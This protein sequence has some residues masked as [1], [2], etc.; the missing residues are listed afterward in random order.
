MPELDSALIELRRFAASPPAAPA[1]M[2]SVIRQ[3]LLLVGRR[4]RL[5]RAGAA[6][7]VVAAAAVALVVAVNEDAPPEPRA[8][9]GP[10]A[11]IES[12]VRSEGL[13]VQPATGLAP[14]DQVSIA[15]PA[16]PAP[17]ATIVQCAS[18]A[19]GELE[20]WCDATSWQLVSG[21]PPDYRASVVRVIQ[22]DHG[23]IDCADRPQRCLIAVRSE[24]HGHAAPI[25]FRA[26]LAPIAEPGLS[27]DR[28]EVSDG[29]R[30]RM[31]GSGF[32]PGAEVRVTQCRRGR[33]QGPVDDFAG[34]DTARTLLV[35]ADA[36]GRFERRILLFR[37]VFEPKSGWVACD[38][39]VLRA[40]AVGQLPATVPLHVIDGGEP[41]AADRADRSG[42]SLPTGS[43]RP[44]PRVGVRGR[45]RR[46]HH[47]M[48]PVRHRRSSHRGAGRGIGAGGLLLPCG[49]LRRPA[50]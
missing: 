10:E 2:A 1:P 23:L 31:L 25:S 26:D 17:G 20:G 29:E 50:R 41:D 8:E 13:T 11:A 38:P 16:D 40:D 32:T 45:L 4:R 15:L 47:R 43:A 9:H 5:T 49:R 36:S 6:F 18:E 37:E 33:G 42:R 30:V 12:T 22:T 48:V 46:D 14:G 27:V 24:G 35:D 39:C 44:A 19:L 7:A 21:G 28:S 3:S 34:C